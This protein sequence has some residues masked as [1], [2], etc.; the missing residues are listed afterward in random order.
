M[1][2][3]VSN[4]DRDVVPR[5]RS[6]RRTIAAGEFQQLVTPRDLLDHH[7]GD[8][9][10]HE[11]E[12]LRAPSTTT[13]AEVVSAARI[14]GLP[15]P[16]EAADLLQAAGETRSLRALGG[17]YHPDPSVAD[18]P[19]IGDFK[20]DEY[21]RARIRHEKAAL[22]RDPR[23]A[24][25]WADLARAYT[26]LGQFGA[27]EH[28][29]R[30]ARI[31][32]PSSRYLL[33]AAARFYVH[34][35][36][37]ER[38]FRLLRDSPRTIQDPWLM[39]AYLSVANNGG[40]TVRSLKPARRIVEDDNF[41]PIERSE[42][43]SEVA[44]FDLRAGVDRR[45]R[46]LF[47]RSL[48]QPTDNSLAQVEWA[49]HRMVNL[50]VSFERVDVP[51]PAEA[52]ARAASQGGQWTEALAQSLRW[53]SDQPFDVEAAV[54]GSYVAA[55]GLEDYTTSVEVADR[56]LRARSDDVTLLNNRAFA[57][58]ELGRTEEA[59]Q[60]LSRAAVTTAKQED[61]IALTATHGLLAFRVGDYETGRALYGRAIE[62][63]RRNTKRSQESM[64]RAM[65]AREELR[66]GNVE[67]AAGLLRALRHL[68]QSVD[69]A[70]FR[71]VLSRLEKKIGL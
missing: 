22:T 51:Y 44:T 30:V 23:N 52:L 16:S 8:Y 29:L 37:A 34:V 71:Q 64:A 65:L 35:R 40:L 21:F 28:A 45:A 53:L 15:V 13:A 18:D 7:Q 54:H 26:A 63:A 14:I 12:W 36:D 11:Q 43:I 5:W 4:D 31:L 58:I 20:P 50:D 47:N 2:A 1:T 9:D 10:E 38:A 59:Q 17:G 24:L 55:T 69:D 68:A 57:L 70:G 66:A 39:A 27:A 49:S 19:E 42:L 25:R 61:R 6:V 62:L 60:S 56:G 3:R 32:A 41:R 46:D 48:I 67:D 33:R